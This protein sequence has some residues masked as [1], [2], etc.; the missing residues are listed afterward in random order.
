VTNR[1]RLLELLREKSVKTGDFTLASGKR[2]D[3][4]VDVRQTSLHSEGAW[5]IATELLAAIGDHIK[6]IGGLTMGADPLACATAAVAHTHGRP[7]HAFLIRKE[8]KG[9]GTGQYVEGLSNFS[10]GSAVA[11][12]EDTTTTGA[13]ML[14]A[15]ERAEAAG[16]K[17]VQCI[18]V[19][20]R[21][22]G[23]AERLNAAGYTLEAL[24]TRSELLS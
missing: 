14:T 20:D 15:I 9:H 11:V 8:A 18:T 4:Y 12:V 22:E 13:S 2:S 21:E 7:L 1:Q 3:F 5:L 10:K 23:A 19:V 6:G 17:V 24:T 16:L